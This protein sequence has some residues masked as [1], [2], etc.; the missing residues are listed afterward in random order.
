MEN[1][2]KYDTQKNI[3]TVRVD[4]FVYV[5]VFLVTVL[6]AVTI[7]ALILTVGKFLSGEYN[8]ALDTCMNKGFT[9]AYCRS[10]L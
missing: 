3:R 7:I 8:E 9:E 5:I 6:V 2:I 1:K 4:W 10:I